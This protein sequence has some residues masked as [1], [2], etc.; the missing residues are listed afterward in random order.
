MLLTLVL[1]ACPGDASVGSLHR[2]QLSHETCGRQDG[3]EPFQ[4]G[5]A[6]CVINDLRERVLG[7]HEGDETYQHRTHERV[8]DGAD[9]ATPSTLVMGGLVA[10]SVGGGDRPLRRVRSKTES[11]A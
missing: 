10:L 7:H 9:V 5:C 2:R 4:N 3:L 8:R 11:G 6:S 1:R